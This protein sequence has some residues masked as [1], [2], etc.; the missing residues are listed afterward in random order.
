MSQFRAELRRDFFRR[1]LYS[2]SVVLGLY[3]IVVVPVS[4]NPLGALAIVLATAFFAVLIPSLLLRRERLDQA[5]L[6]F[7]ACGSTPILFTFWFGDTIDTPAAVAQLGFLVQAAV[8][9]ERRHA[10]WLGVTFLLVDLA[11]VVVQSLGLD[12]PVYLPSNAFAAWAIIACTIAWV[13][14]VLFL[15]N[16]TLHRT[17][18][19]LQQ[20]VIELRE[21]NERLLN[22]EQLRQSIT[23]TAP[24]GILVFDASGRN[25]FAN[26]F[27]VARLGE[28]VL[29]SQLDRLPWPV[30]DHV[31]TSIP[32]PE[33]PFRQVLSSQR[34]LYGANL[35]IERPAGRRIYLSVSVAPLGPRDEGIVVAFED[36]SGRIEM[37]RRHIHAQRLASMGQLAGSIAHDFN[38]FLTVIR[39]D[40]QLALLNV[41]PDAALRAR[42]ERIYKTSNNASAVCRQLLAFARRDEAPAQLFSLNM[43]IQEN[44]DTFRSLLHPNIELSMNLGPNLPLIMG[45]STLLLQVLM[46]LTL[47]ARDAM[48]HGGKL[49]IQT[50]ALDTG[51]MLVV[52]DTG[53]GMDDATLN[54]LFEPYFTTKPAGHGTGLGMAIVYG[55]VQQFGG[56]IRAESE[57]G[58]GTRFLIRLPAAAAVATQPL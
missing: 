36:V 24:V 16:D 31:G 12:I 5:A 23:E 2:S 46:N 58:K 18:S 38:N 7:I 6:V 8:L 41:S 44:I 47:N 56:W 25:V 43:L 11:K 19:Q 17:L 20:Q 28:E 53:A 33:Q 55:V 13:A 34:A 10:V 54:T 1:A 40:S 45:E 22:S 57:L 14:P 15:V 9:L 3:L 27:A 48:P 35:A 21:T 49:S 51:M 52:E 39:G 50:L 32:I 42:L 4:P 26:S 30:T 37:E 29:W